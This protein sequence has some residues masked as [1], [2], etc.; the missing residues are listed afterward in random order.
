MDGRSG[1]KCRVFCATIRGCIIERYILCTYIKKNNIYNCMVGNFE[2]W[3]GKQN[4]GWD[5]DSYKNDRIRNGLAMWYVIAGKTDS[6]SENRGKTDERNCDWCV[7]E[8]QGF[9][10]VWNI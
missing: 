8:M 1:A 10:A 7:Q 6:E 2:R 3:T 9:V 4:G 5:C